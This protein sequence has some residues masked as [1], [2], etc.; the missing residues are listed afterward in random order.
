MPMFALATIPLIRSL[1]DSVTQIWYADDGAALGNISDLRTW[2][3]N[4]TY[5]GPGFGYFTNS[6]KTWLVTKESCLS[7]A[8]AKFEDTNINITSD[9]RPYLGAPLGTLEYGSK[10]VS[11]N[12]SKWSSELQLLSEIAITQPHAAYTALIHSRILQQ[13]VLPVTHLT[14]HQQHFATLGKHYSHC[15]YSTTK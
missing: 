1:P 14:K 15:F 2:S 13:M 5:L 3:D 8:I 7:D 12:V 6:A 10:F 11:E 4:L 9:G